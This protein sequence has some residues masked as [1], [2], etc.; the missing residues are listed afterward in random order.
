[1]HH[2]PLIWEYYPMKCVRSINT[3]PLSLFVHHLHQS[4]EFHEQISRPRRL[5]LYRDRWHLLASIRR[6][7]AALRS[8][9]E[10]RAECE[11]SQIDSISLKMLKKQVALPPVHCSI[12][13]DLN[14]LSGWLFRTLDS[15]QVSIGLAESCRILVIQVLSNKIGPQDGILVSNNISFWDVSVTWTTFWQQSMSGNCIRFVCFEQYC[16]SRFDFFLWRFCSQLPEP[17]L[18]LQFSCNGF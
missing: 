5:A 11:S 15:S 2:F 13:A 6:A 10:A 17:L 4:L 8:P 3:F 16:L 12:Q 14:S 9:A 1:M 7:A 18:D